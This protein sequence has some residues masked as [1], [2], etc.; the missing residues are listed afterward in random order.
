MDA[1]F[2]EGRIRAKALQLVKREDALREAKREVRGR[3]WR[4]TAGKRGHVLLFHREFREL[5]IREASFELWRKWWPSLPA[6]DLRE[7]INRL[8]LAVLLYS[9][10]RR[11]GKDLRMWWTL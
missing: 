10:H 8:S 7:T 3:R 2:L 5:V 6:S 1:R 4:T 9:A 11:I